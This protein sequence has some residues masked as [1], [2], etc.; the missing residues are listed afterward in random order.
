MTF[1]LLDNGVKDEFPLKFSRSEIL[2][3]KCA[4]EAGGILNARGGGEENPS[5]AMI[6]AA[7]TSESDKTVD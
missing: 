2:S 7:G 6:S 3:D 5:L 1:S 4:L